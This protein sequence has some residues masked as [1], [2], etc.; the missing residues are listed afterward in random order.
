MSTYMTVRAFA[1]HVGVSARTIFRL[2]A[3]GLPS[4]LVGGSRRVP[5]EKATA[6]LGRRTPRR[7]TA[8]ETT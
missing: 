1:A 6:W 3:L 8:R 7:Q 2:I 4:I 5:R